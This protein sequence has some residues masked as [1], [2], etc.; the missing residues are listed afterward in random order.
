MSPQLAEFFEFLRFPSISTDS[1]HRDDVRACADYLVQKFNSM[2]LKPELHETPG[3]PV[4][5]AR[6]EPRPDRPTVLIYGHYDVQPVD[7]VSEWDTPPFEP[8]LKGDKIFA[9]GATDNKGQH[10]AHM[11]GV[12]E[13]I[14]E[15][16]DLPVNVIFLIEGEEE[17]GSPNLAPFLEKNRE[18]LACDICAVSDT[19]MIGP[20]IPTLTYGLR[21]V[22]CLEFTVHGPSLDLHSG[23]YGGAVPNPAT[24]VAR[25]VASLHDENGVI[26]IPG[27]YDKVIPLEKWERDMWASL[28]DGQAATIAETGVP[29]LWGEAGYTALEQRW[30][31]PTAEVN[32]IGG[33]YQG[34]G[35]KTVI[36]REAMA[37]LSFRLVP[38]QNPKEILE[39]AK[40]HLEKV[41]PDSCR[42][43]VELGHS[44]PA[45]VM[46]PHSTYGKAAQRAL[47]KAFSDEPRLI[48]EGGSIPI[49]QA[50]KDILG[51]DSLLLG[52]ALPDCQIHAPNENFT[53]TNFEAGI[54]LN[55]ALLEEL[56]N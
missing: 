51:V 32:G 11:L 52:L 12:E 17:I 25:M 3:H 21:G 5:V 48:R 7:P 20:G 28:P 39:L 50:I 33:G 38:D 40:A 54:Q 18:S 19:G 45:Y 16:G 37:K 46:D 53:V 15:H 14:K 6:S 8:T 27:F 9:R 42:I 55:R 10:F 35:S 22:A 1:S 24:M 13:T 49:I 4:V 30:G 23:V 34:E 2:G 26:Q 56:G 41:C 31:R 29:G 43:E 47:Q 36:A 44:G